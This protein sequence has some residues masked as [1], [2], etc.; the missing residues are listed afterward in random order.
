M[1][2]LMC[3]PPLE[4]VSEETK[5][6]YLKEYNGL[7]ESLKK[8]AQLVTKALREM[9]NITTN[10]VEGAMYAFPS[11]KFSKKVAEAAE[12]KAPDVFYSLELLK[13]TGI[14]VVPGSGFKQREGTHHFRITTLVLPEE[15]FS[16]KL[17]SLKKF[18]EEFHKKY[19]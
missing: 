18:N 17:E 3:N 13:K 12:G 9:R 1:I 6:L 4:G 16:K 8:R 10:E 14:C 2:D 11:V 7:F 5:S 15:R 19:E